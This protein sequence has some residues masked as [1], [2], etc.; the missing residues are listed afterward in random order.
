MDLGSDATVRERIVGRPLFAGIVTL[1]LVACAPTPPT[2]AASA[3]P[4]SPEAPTAPIPTAAAAATSSPPPAVGIS[5]TVTSGPTGRP[6]RAFVSAHD[7]RSPDCRRVGRAVVPDDSGRFA[8]QVPAGTYRVRFSALSAGLATHWW[9]AR[10]GQTAL[11]CASASNVDV[12]ARSVAGIN[13]ALIPGYRIGGAVTAGGAPSERNVLLFDSATRGLVDGRSGAGG[14]Y[15]FQVPNGSYR[16]LFQA[17]GPCPD[18]WWD[19]ATE[20]EKATVVVV[21][22]ADVSDIDGQC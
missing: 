10:A 19:R 21:Q 20:F 5:G 16:V 7:G 14:R 4:T 1:A 8:L 6:A 18:Q 15:S 12:T 13:A 3:T 17:D 22:G 9:D 2:G 11:T